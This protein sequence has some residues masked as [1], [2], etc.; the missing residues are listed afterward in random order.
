MVHKGLNPYSGHQ[1]VD[2]ATR[3][4]TDT[5]AGR[6]TLRGVTR[7]E[8]GLALTQGGWEKLERFFSGLTVPAPI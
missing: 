8:L 3:R 6:S 4:D 2:H 1:P 5:D 7:R